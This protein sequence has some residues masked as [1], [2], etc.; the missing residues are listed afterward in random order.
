MRDTVSVFSVAVAVA[1]VEKRIQMCVVL[2]RA[3]L[4]Y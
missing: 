3:Q 2:N 4:P 1:A